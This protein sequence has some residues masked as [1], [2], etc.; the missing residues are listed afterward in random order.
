MS[1]VQL[2]PTV[3]LVP[4][5]VSLLRTMSPV[6]KPGDRLNDRS[7]VGDESGPVLVIVNVWVPA[8]NRYS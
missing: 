5:H 7:S 3:R 1:K 2:P 6:G 8:L 4:L